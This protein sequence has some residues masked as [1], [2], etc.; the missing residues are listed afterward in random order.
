MGKPDNPTQPGA[1]D[2]ARVDDLVAEIEDGVGLGGRTLGKLGSTG[3]TQIGADLLRETEVGGPG[4]PVPVGHPYD[5]GMAGR[6]ARGG[7]GSASDPVGDEQS[8][9]ESHDAPDDQS[10]R[11]R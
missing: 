11:Q 7:L 9:A 3:G 5:P 8:P 6:T 2:E 1:D 10:A 4:R